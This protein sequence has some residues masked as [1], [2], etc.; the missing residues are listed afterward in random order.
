MGLVMAQRS[1]PLGSWGPLR[2]VKLARWQGVREGTTRTYANTYTA[3]QRS[4]S[5]H[6]I[7]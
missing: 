6:R 7:D 5:V 1:S 4:R 3:C 2:K